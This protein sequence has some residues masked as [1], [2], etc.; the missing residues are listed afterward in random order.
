MNSSPPLR[1]P[2]IEVEEPE[3]DDAVV[4]PISKKKQKKQPRPPKSPTPLPV[5]SPKTALDNLIKKQQKLEGKENKEQRKKESLARR[6]VRLEE[7]GELASDSE[8]EVYSD[9]DMEGG[10][11][12]YNS[13]RTDKKREEREESHDELLMSDGKLFILLFLVSFL[14]P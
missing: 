7:D 5:T 14:I 8:S 13:S 12:S 4:L 1:S 10:E 11:E 9:S 6:A 3:S 2:P